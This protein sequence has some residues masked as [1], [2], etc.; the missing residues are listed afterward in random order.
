MDVHLSDLTFLGPRPPLWRLVWDEVRRDIIPL[1]A[2]ALA[3]Q[4]LASWLP[5]LA[6]AMAVLSGPAFEQQREIVLDRLAT[7]WVPPV[8]E[9]LDARDADPNLASSVSEPRE[10]FKQKCR[11]TIQIMALN[12]GSIGTFSFIALLIIAGLLYRTV[13]ETFN[14]IWKVR[15]GRGFFMKVAI[16]TVFIF[17]G[18]VFLLLS[19]SL[20]DGHAPPLLNRWCMPTLLSTVG[21]T[22][23]FL[24]MPNARVRFTAALAGGLFAA[25]VWSIGKQGMLIYISHAVGASRFYGSLGLVP[26]VFAWVYLSWLVVLAGAEL[27]YIIQHHRAMVEQWEARQREARGLAGVMDQVQREA[28][29]LP[30]M[31][32]AALCEVARLFREGTRPGGVRL[33]ELAESLGVETGPLSR[34]ID[35]L[36]RGGLLAQVAD[37]TVSLSGQ[38]P[39]FLPARDPAQCHADLMLSV[40]RGEESPEG[41]GLSW[42]RA[43]GFLTRV[44]RNGLTAVNALT[45]AELIAPRPALSGQVDPPDTPPSGPAAQ[46]ATTS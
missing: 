11:D 14:G 40:C 19:F 12:L 33:S 7:A 17:W 16:L 32:L 6:I 15:S 4:T 20:T 29:Q 28:G 36:V 24:I 30:A 35:R 23:F 22:A 18:P 8:P 21:F 2:S 46:P 34:A 13:E 41:S 45:L 42:E 44:D 10:Q 38:D 26:L 31:A 25:V 39:R 27:A 9:P 1:R 37:H 3:F 43:R 5:L